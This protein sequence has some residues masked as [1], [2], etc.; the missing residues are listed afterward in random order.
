[1]VSLMLS[2]EKPGRFSELKSGRAC[3]ESMEN[4]LELDEPPFSVAFCSSYQLPKEE[5][6]MVFELWR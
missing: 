2:M 6:G 4:Q 1:M 5:L 3:S